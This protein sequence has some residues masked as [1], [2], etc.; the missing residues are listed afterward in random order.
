MIQRDEPDDYVIGTGNTFSVKDVIKTAFDCVG[1]NWKEYIR[2]D[3]KLYRPAEIF[4]LRADYTKAK[5][6][7][8]WKP[9]ISF[10]KLIEKMVIADL[11]ALK[12]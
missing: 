8:Q 10:E 2:I 4:E 6:E 7:L 5:S 12:K 11:E 1:L 9:T 3:E